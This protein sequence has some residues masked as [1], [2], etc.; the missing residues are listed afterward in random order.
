M[1]NLYEIMQAAQQG[2]A[3]S[4]MAR[5]FGLSADQT[6][7]AIEAV[8]PA[9][10]LGLQRSAQNPQDWMKAM[11]MM[12]A[13]QF[14]PFFEPPA[15]APPPGSTASPNMV[16]VLF[17]SPE[18]TRQVAA[19]AAVLS[20]VNPEVLVRMLPLIGGMIMGNLFKTAMEQGMAQVM[21][22]AADFMQ[23]GGRP[24]GEP[25]KA[26]PQPA[27][28]AATPADSAADMM[29][30]M[31]A[32]SLKAM[33]GA[34]PL[35]AS[36]TATPQ[37]A[38]PQAAPPPPPP[39]PQP[40]DAEQGNAALEKHLGRMIE[41]G[42]AVQE[43]N[44]ATMRAIFDSFAA[45]QGKADRPPADGAGDGMPAHG[46]SGGSSPTGKGSPEAA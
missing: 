39:E 33:F 38:A 10:S 22:Q 16:D 21:S 20:G 11:G 43:Q 45:S 8:L 18:V 1:Y 41:T 15:P 3:A 17:G 34:F 40:D 5:Q 30:Q 25:A 2:Q 44:L 13:S 14:T 37:S 19:H 32:N 46:A 12:G 24:Q 36:G 42:R 35:S 27:P 29:G 23:T 4:N 26:K 7:K 9:F 6:R 28:Q 31:V